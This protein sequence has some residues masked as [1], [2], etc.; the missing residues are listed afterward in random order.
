MIHKVCLDLLGRLIKTEGE[1]CALGGFSRLR[2]LLLLLGP[3]LLFLLLYFCLVPVVFLSEPNPG[4]WCALGYL[5]LLF[6]CPFL[7]GGR[8]L[9]AK[10]S[11]VTALLWAPLS[12]SLQWPL[13]CFHVPPTCLL[14]TNQWIYFFITVNRKSGTTSWL[15][16]QVVLGSRRRQKILLLI[17]SKS[18]R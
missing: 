9:S 14:G 4:L 3:I 8:C 2:E 17:I 12:T 15:F 6:H 18:L 16:C 10:L 7:P 13:E 1:C 5:G 11:Y